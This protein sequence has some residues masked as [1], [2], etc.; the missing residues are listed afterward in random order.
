VEVNPALL[1]RSAHATLG[2]DEA[3]CVE[4]SPQPGSRRRSL[5]LLDPP[6]SGSR[7]LDASGSA[8]SMSPVRS[9]AV[10]FFAVGTNMDESR[11]RAWLPSAQRLTVGSL[12]GYALRWHKRSRQGGKLSVLCTG[13]PDDVVWGVVYELD[14]PASETVDAAQREAG[15]REEVVTVIAINGDA[16][17]VSLYIAREDMIDDT[18]RPTA[19]YRDP[20]VAAARAN[21]LPRAYVEALARTPVSD[22][23]QNP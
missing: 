1:A 15:Y 19:S 20:I 12:P 10:N 23:H 8:S 7:G 21:H 3:P 4:S 6:A 9:G 22:T 18:L 5:P 14:G 13:L 11:L 17:D 2:R 16:L